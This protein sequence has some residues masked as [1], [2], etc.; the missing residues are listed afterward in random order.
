MLLQVPTLEGAKKDLELSAFEASFLARSS[1]VAAAATSPFSLFT[2]GAADE[3]ALQAAGRELASKGVLTQARDG[4]ALRLPFAESARI[5]LAAPVLVDVAWL[6]AAGKRP[7]RSVFCSDGAFVV[8]V[9][10]RAAGVRLS[11]PA[12]ASRWADVLARALEVGEPDAWCHALD[13][14]LYR[15]YLLVAGELGEA[16]PRQAI[17]AALAGTGLAG[18]EEAAVVVESLLELGLLEARGEEL[19]PAP[20]FSPLWTALANAECVI[21]SAQTSGGDERTASLVGHPG[22]RLLVQPAS[23]GEG[24]VLSTPGCAG[25]RDYFS[26]LLEL[27]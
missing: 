6:G 12:P 3:H 24:V 8:Q 26:S 9:W 25:V 10:A 19:S 27:L 16:A 23:E 22:A 11:A 20:A 7:R 15:L 21:V 13:A 17:E 4:L 18:L 5:A 2:R 14:T 1:S